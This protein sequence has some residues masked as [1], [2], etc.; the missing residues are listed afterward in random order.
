MVGRKFISLLAAPVVS[1]GVASVVL[2]VGA[3]S[4]L[5]CVVGPNDDGCVRAIYRVQRTDG[6]LA[7]WSGPGTGQI[8]GWLYGNGTAVQVVCQTTGA[9]EDGLPYVVWDKLVDGTYVYDYYLDT[10]GDAYTPALATCPGPGGGPNPSPPPPPGH[11]P[12]PPNKFNAAG[13]AAWATANATSSPIPG[14]NGY[15]ADDCTDFVSRAMHIGGGMPERE[16]QNDFP[17]DH[18]DDHDWYLR[19]WREGS[20]ELRIATRSWTAAPH[21]LAYLRNAGLARQVTLQAARPGDLIFVNW[22]KGGHDLPN[23]QTD[24]TS[25]AGIDHVGMIVGNPFR[26]P[27]AQ[28]GYDVQIA[29]HSSNKIE[30]LF[31]WQLADHNLHYW[32]YS[33]YYH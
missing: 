11:Q 1:L 27:L 5:A 28:D 18:T 24:T 4:A 12:A 7:Q 19:S 20:V 32:I 8:V 6:S 33:I 16:V 31:D 21:L 29:Q 2:L 25:P 15:L 10:P 22:G 23:G 3:G 30:D 13:A 14:N 26:D 17:S 9:T